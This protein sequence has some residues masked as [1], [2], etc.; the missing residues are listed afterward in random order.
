MARESSDFESLKA[1]ND[2]KQIILSSFFFIATLFSEEVHDFK[3]KHFLAS[4]LDCDSEALGAVEEV[5]RAMDLAVNQSNA[6]ILDKAS[7]VFSPNGLTIVYLLSESHASLHTYPEFNACFVDL[8]TCGDHCDAQKFDA[9]LR[10]Y[11]KPK[12]VNARLF[13][14]HQG[15]E[16]IPLEQF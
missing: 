2:M 4:Y 15:I 3:G 7:Y 14:R 13:V 12:E 10:A 5:I 8:F 1:G 6:T 11:L 16:E 9:A